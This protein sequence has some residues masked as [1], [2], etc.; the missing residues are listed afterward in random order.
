M[1]RVRRFQSRSASR[2]TRIALSSSC[3]AS[4]KSTIA[5][6]SAPVPI[7]AAVVSRACDSPP[8]ARAPTPATAK[9]TLAKAFQTVVAAVPT[10]TCS[11]PKPQRRNIEYERPMPTASPPGSTLEAAVEAI[12][13]TSA[14]MKDRPGNA[15]IQGGAKVAR[16]SSATTTSAAMSCVLR[17]VM[18]SQTSP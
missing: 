17:P 6:T 13:S 1:R 7:S 14:C 10:A 4:V 15:A 5:T 11:T 12:E 18:I 16:L 2:P 9:M 3:S 8:I